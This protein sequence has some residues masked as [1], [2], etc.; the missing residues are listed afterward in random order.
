M[1]MTLFEIAAKLTLDSSEYQDGIEKAKGSAS[2]IGE[3]LSTAAKVGGA[4]LTAAATA[5][6]G[7]TKS[8]VTAFADYEQLV[9]GV[10]T[11][12]GESSSKVQEYRANAYKTAGLSANRYMETVTGFSASLLQ[13][14]GGDTAKAADVADMAVTDMADNA[15]KM[16]TSIESI[17]TAYQ[18]FAKQNYT[19]LDNL[20]LGYGGTKEEMERLLADASKLSGIK[21]DISSFSDIAEAIHVVQDNMGI[22]NA[23]A[24]EAATTIQGSFGAIKGAWTNLLAGLGTGSADIGKLM[25]NLSE[26]V[27]TFIGGKDGNGNLIGAITN[28]LS[29]IGP[30]I[31]AMAPMISESLPTLISTL[32]P[33][34]MSAAASLLSGFAE[35]LIAAAPSLLDTAAEIINSLLTGMTDNMAQVLDMALTLIT[36]LITGVV[37]NLPLI[38]SNGISL[39]YSFLSGLI[40]KLPEVL[41]FASDMVIKMGVALIGMAPELI[42]KGLSLIGQLVEELGKAA[43]D[44]GDAVIKGVWQGIQDAASWFWDQVTGFFS[45][46]VDGVKKNLGIESP[47]KVFAEIGGYMAQGLGVGWDKELPGIKRA[48]LADMDFG[49][50]TPEVVPAAKNDLY[51]DYPYA[52]RTGG[53]VTIVQNIYSERKTAADLEEEALYQAKKRLLNV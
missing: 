39:I 8:A 47:S 36:T 30:A 22:T 11:L 37:E 14:L 51:S 24:E 13:S 44:I 42:E 10:D 27:M 40:S 53:T 23:T 5:V 4:A 2:G 20:K 41:A 12:F 9:G 19:M 1:A 18:G 33:A 6:G 48:M 3:A 50:L 45:G 17:Q 25:E 7:L 49:A 35:G 26:T 52:A 34:L 31:E 21:Y 28:V 16:G 29:G 46:I 43:L 32:L 15:N 38:V